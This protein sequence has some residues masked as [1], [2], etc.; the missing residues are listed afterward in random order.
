MSK[1]PCS[2]TDDPSYDYSDYIEGKG[3]YEP[4]EGEYDDPAKEDTVYIEWDMQ[5]QDA[6]SIFDQIIKAT[7]GDKDAN[8]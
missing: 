8:N 7:S 4:Y 2:V 3:V 1:M 5:K 6:E